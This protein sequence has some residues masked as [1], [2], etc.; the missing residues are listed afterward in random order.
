MI[1]DI[2][3]ESQRLLGKHPQSPFDRMIN[4]AVA[5]FF[6]TLYYCDCQLNLHSFGFWMIHHGTGKRSF[7]VCNQCIVSTINITIHTIM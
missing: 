4:H 5:R 1:S 6:K 3:I 2:I 7:A